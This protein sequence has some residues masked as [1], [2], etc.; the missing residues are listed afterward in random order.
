[1]E[2]GRSKRQF[3][4]SKWHELSKQ[5]FFHDHSAIKILIRPL[6]AGAFMKHRRKGFSLVELL[7]CIGIVGLLLAIALPAVQGARE[8]ARRIQCSSNLR[9]LVTAASSYYDTFQVIPTLSSRSSVWWRLC[10]FFGVKLGGDAEFGVIDTP[11]VLQCPSDFDAAGNRAA[12]YCVN[13]GTGLSIELDGPLIG[14]KTTFTDANISDG[15]S[16]TAFASEFVRLKSLSLP[17]S[18]SDFRPLIFGLTG[19]AFNSTDSLYMKAQKCLEVDTSREIIFSYRRG[20]NWFSGTSQ[21]DWGYSHALVPGSKS[22]SLDGGM[23]AWTPGSQ[24]SSG[25]NV[26]KMD[27]SV[28]FVSSSVDLIIWRARGT[29][30]GNEVFENQ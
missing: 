26:A 16:N 23:L 30:S 2:P 22:C 28:S 17:V 4:Y 19:G 20:K 8:S 12:N 25:V 18:R 24:H 9:Q 1:M 13:L 29:R 21:S 10:P 27:G 5:P 3:F 6:C 7:V 11:R 15:M 14:G